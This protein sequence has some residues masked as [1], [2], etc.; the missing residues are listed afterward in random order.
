MDNYAVEQ[1]M[2]HVKHKR[3]V[4]LQTFVRKR[5]RVKRGLRNHRQAKA[6]C[7]GKVAAYVLV[8]GL[9]LQLVLQLVSCIIKL[10]N[11]RHVSWMNAS[12][13]NALKRHN[14]IRKPARLCCRNKS[15]IKHKSHA[16]TRARLYG[17]LHEYL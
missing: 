3:I 8:D 15:R 12:A 5:L 2:R 9:I 7:V 16:R 14:V 6:R 11:K 10:N 17:K 4:F 1:Q 13:Y